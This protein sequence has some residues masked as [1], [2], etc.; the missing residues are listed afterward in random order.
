MEKITVLNDLRDL[1][2]KPQ[3]FFTRYKDAKVTKI[4]LFPIAFILLCITFW[5]DK[6]DRVLLKS[7][8]SESSNLLV[9]NWLSYWGLSIV[10]GI[11]AGILMYYLG[12][13]F[14]NLR[15]KWSKGE[16]SP[17]LSRSIYIY[18][19]L[20]IWVS[21]FI[22]TLVD[23]ILY[24]TPIDVYTVEFQ[25]KILEAGL[26]VLSWIVIIHSLFISYKAVTLIKWISKIRAIIWFIVLPFCTYA[27]VIWS[28]F[29]ML[30][31]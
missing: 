4:W 1:C 23:T 11:M 16:D 28:I 13:W 6:V 31:S 19:Y 30:I 18:S 2:I 10:S 5:V 21:T 14:Y 9:Q 22:I 7:I 25:A 3:N 12:G 8:S 27:L 15:V 17:E 24:K 26:I 20:F 29:Q